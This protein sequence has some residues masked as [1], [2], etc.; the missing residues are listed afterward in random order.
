MESWRAAENGRQTVA[1][2]PVHFIDSLPT[3]SNMLDN[4]AVGL[5]AA[6]LMPWHQQSEQG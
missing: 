6:L 5:I 1:R 4:A 3:S 2:D